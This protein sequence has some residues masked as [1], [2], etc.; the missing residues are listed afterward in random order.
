MKTIAIIG[1]MGP[2]ASLF[3]Q[4][5]LIEKLTKAKVKANTIHVT[6]DIEHFFD[7][8]KPS[9]KLSQSQQDLLYGY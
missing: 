7:S 2:Q 5:K 1:G 4:E 3:A 6:L 8:K 9:L